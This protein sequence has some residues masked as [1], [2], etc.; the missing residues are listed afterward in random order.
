MRSPERIVIGIG[1]KRKIIS[2]NAKQET[3]NAVS[4]TVT[5]EP[6]RSDLPRH[7]GVFGYD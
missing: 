5:R 3:M 1:V 4:P 7:V 6:C 2:S